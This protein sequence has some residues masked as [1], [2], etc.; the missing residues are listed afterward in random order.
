MIC[1]IPI[2]TC[3]FSNL[4][5]YKVTYLQNK[6]YIANSTPVLNRN[7]R[8]NHY[9][10]ITHLK[11]K[12]MQKKYSSTIFHF[13]ITHLQFYSMFLFNSNFFLWY[14]YRTC[15]HYTYTHDMITI[16]CFFFFSLLSWTHS[17]AYVVDI[18]SQTSKKQKT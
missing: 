16:C 18:D 6:M 1:T 2:S 17:C 8:L 5:R 12:C 14:D 15:Y 13:I 3:I 9:N 7:M 10:I 11:T 4:L